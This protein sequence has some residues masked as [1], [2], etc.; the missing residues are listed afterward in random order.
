MDFVDVGVEHCADPHA[1]YIAEEALDS[2][3]FPP[4]NHCHVMQ[5]EELY[6]NFDP[7]KVACFEFF[8]SSFLFRD[9]LLAFY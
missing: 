8:A 5:F 4:F 3:R 7:M 6:D 2:E 9:R 1:S